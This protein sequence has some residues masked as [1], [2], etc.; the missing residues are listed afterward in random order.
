M[1]TLEGKK[2]ELLARAL[3][4]KNSGKLSDEEYAQI[5]EVLMP[6][7]DAWLDIDYSVPLSERID[8]LREQSEI[9]PAKNANNGMVSLKERYLQELSELENNPNPDV[10]AIK[11]GLYIERIVEIAEDI[12]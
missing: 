3:D 5:T 2:Q 9:F 10:E 11:I 8:Y 12:E 7:H 1:K 6:R 4:L